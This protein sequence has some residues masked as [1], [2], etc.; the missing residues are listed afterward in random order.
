MPI[1][2]RFTPP[3]W[4]TVKGMGFDGVQALMLNA[5]S[6]LVLKSALV[7]GRAALACAGR[8]GLSVS[9]VI[10]ACLLGAP[11]VGAASGPSPSNAAGIYSC[12][13][14]RGRRITSDRPIPDCLDRE[15]RVLNK[16]GSQRK[17]LPPRQSPQERLL[18]EEVERER[19]R[20]KQALL[21]AVR[22]DRKLML[23][24]PDEAVHA[25]AR[26]AALDDVRSGMARSE[27]RV[28]D[29]KVERKTLLAEAA[30]YKSRT[31]PFKL[32]SELEANEA[33]QSAQTKIIA[34]H[35]SE[36]ARVNTKYEHELTRLRQLWAGAP[37]GT[38]PAASAAP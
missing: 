20:Q 10:V 23:R 11:H 5:S 35:V 26:E 29:L 4:R 2:Q 21:A 36:M 24:Y 30:F 1:W 13:D 7:C 12:M 17:V 6:A 33:M 9:A 16:D 28:K 37:P 32:K 19:E 25:K 3:F 31:M 22:R 34:N 27:K 14:A 18:A 38:L 15:Q 8:S